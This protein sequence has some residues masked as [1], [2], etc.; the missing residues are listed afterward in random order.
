MRKALI[1][2]M[3][4]LA[5]STAIAAPTV[6]FA[7]DGA[8]APTSASAST[9]AQRSMQLSLSSSSAKAG[10]KIQ[11]TARTSGLAT[12]VNVSSKALSDVTV[13]HGK[14]NIWTGTATVAKVD[15][16][17]Y[18]VSGVAVIDGHKVDT[19]A[20]L[21]V[22]A[23]KPKPPV[24]ATFTMSKENGA[25]GEKVGFTVKNAKG[26][27]TVA[28]DAFGGTVHLVQ[29]RSADGT[30]HGE[31]TVSKN[32]KLGYY[33]VKA[34]DGKTLIDT[35]KFTVSEGR[36]HDKDKPKPKPTPVNPNQH[37]TP[38]GSVNTGMAPVGET[39]GTGSGNGTGLA[40]G[41]GAALAGVGM[42]GGSRA[43]TNR[44]RDGRSNG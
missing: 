7:A 19:S 13:H 38:K 39:N 23:D 25:V 24:S 29:D 15:A 43:L 9:D 34:Y 41:A 2:P 18:G 17:G 27:V 31:G 44:R 12:Q 10:E 33:G 28:S 37:K 30:W 4:A 5:A 8:S 14:G 20:Q 36:Q 35:L 11:I 40:I 16:G 3:I 32:G 42:L 22:T 1:V 6:A 26:P 21:T